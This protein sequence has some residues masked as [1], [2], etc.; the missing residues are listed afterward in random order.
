[1]SKVQYKATVRRGVLVPFPGIADRV[2][3]ELSQF[4]AD[5]V[6][7]VTVEPPSKRRTKRQNDRHWSLIVPAFEQLGHERFS[8]WAEESGM[9]PKD[10][11]HNT[12]KQMFLDPLVLP[13]PDGR[14]VHVWPSSAHLTTAQFS[15]M[16]ERAERYLNSLNIYLPAKEEE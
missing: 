12:I 9:T 3:Q 5:S 11:A 16:D 2:R 6:L 8:Q 4:P 14:T 15:M 10:S 7:D 1:M 13:L